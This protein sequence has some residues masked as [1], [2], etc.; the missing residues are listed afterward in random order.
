MTDII[1][2]QHG[3]S[4]LVGRKLTNAM[5]KLVSD[6]ADAVDEM[7][8][9]DGNPDSKAYAAN[10][11][12]HRSAYGALERVL[13]ALPDNPHFRTVVLEYV[14]RGAEM[15][16]FDPS[17][18]ELVRKCIGRAA[19]DYKPDTPTSLKKTPKAA[20]PLPAPKGKEPGK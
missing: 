12:A 4:Q 10:Y 13:I 17:S 11:L 8:P 6:L 3:S 1:D 19:D 16:A 7:F 5:T 2:T 14:K 20:Q 18:D 9:S 15:T